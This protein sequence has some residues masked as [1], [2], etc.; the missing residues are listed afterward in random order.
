MYDSQ[1]QKSITCSHSV[2]RE[3]FSNVSVGIMLSLRRRH[4]R[5][6]T[7]GFGPDDR[8]NK[9]C[10]CVVHAEGT[11][12]S[13]EKIRVS[14]HTR[15]W[16]EASRIVV[17]AESRGYWRAPQDSQAKLL[18][19]AYDAFLADCESVKGRAL[20]PSTLSS[21]KTL[22]RKLEVFCTERAIVRLSDMTSERV[23]QFRDSLPTGPRS[24]GNYLVKLSCA[25]RFFLANEW[26]DKNPCVSVKVAK[27]KADDKQKHPFTE[28]E[29]TRIL[30]QADANKTVLAL[31][32]LMRTTGLRISDAVFLRR[33]QVVGGALKVK[34]LKSGTNVS[35]PLQPD[36]YRKL[37]ELPATFGTHF[38]T[39][40][41]SR[42]GTA[43][44][45]YRRKLNVI[46]EAAG[47]G[48]G[49]PHRFRHTAAVGW[50][51][52][53]MSTED[54]SRLLGHS[55]P[56]VTARFYSSWTQ[57]RMDRLAEELKK[58]WK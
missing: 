46:F 51:L 17:E 36:V 40:T 48:N 49:T 12:P 38:F 34:T 10:N 29:M 44:D 16:N 18:L 54:V 35:M 11:L 37:S 31:I 24:T 30:Q 14:L 55:G 45:F 47:I 50:L 8:L 53:G 43:T 1:A 15:N 9:R 27:S 32:W 28:E 23:R 3:E 2:F 13:K 42:L 57:S 39:G 20:R 21:Y 58:T 25:F 7:G 41:G 33:D 22:R 52:A 19:E 4:T 56:Q 6:C 5:S 26:L